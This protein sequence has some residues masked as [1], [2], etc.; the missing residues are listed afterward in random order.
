MKEHPLFPWDHF[1]DQPRI[2]R[3]KKLKRRIYLR[4]SWQFIKTVLLLPLFP[5]FCLILLFKKHWVKSEVN[6]CIG[7]A[8][9]VETE[10]EGKTI[11]PL[12]QVREM[13]DELGVNQVLVRI[14]LAASEHFDAY[15]KHID[16]LSAEGREVSVNFLQDRLVLDDVVSLKVILR[17]LLPRLRGKVEYIHVGSAY[18]RRKWAFFHFGEYFKF[19]QSIRSVCLEVSPEMKLI[20]G[21]V[22]DFE[23][24]SFLESLFHFRRGNYDGY[25]I[26]LYVDRRGAPENKQAGFNLL[27]KINLI[28][29]MRQCS[30]KAKGTLWISEIN[31]PLKDTEPFAPCYG[32]VLVDEEE[33]ADFLVRA[34]LLAIASGQIRT[35]YWHQLIAPGYGLVDNRGNAVIKRPS[36][37]A[38]RTLNRLFNGA[39][40]IHFSNGNY[41][42]IEGLY[43]I[44]VSVELSGKPTIVQAFWSNSGNHKLK[45][46]NVDRWLDQNGE[47][48]TFEN[49]SEIPIH[50]RVF[51]ALTAK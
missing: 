9:H 20:G 48:L 37:H 24:P 21:S 33:Q 49:N 1:S 2:L 39:E 22:I 23:L 36:Y 51:Y 29:L 6:Q 8:V 47:S 16:A 25:G 50:G 42:K 19:F 38:F 14:P 15:I 5:V 46:D 35:C 3:D 43:S 12:D 41:T 40:V 44:R 18:N 34:Y 4:A 45:L 28:E 7:L 32:E 17:D 27:K 26:Q 10:C 30:W 31:W 13:V 11:V